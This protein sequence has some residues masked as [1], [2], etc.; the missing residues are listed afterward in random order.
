MKKITF[1]IAVLISSPSFAKAQELSS[2]LS[3]SISTV[4]LIKV[5]VSLLFVLVAIGSFSIIM[6]RLNN[7]SKAGGSTIKI[8][9]SRNVGLKEKLIIVEVSNQQVL[10]G[11]TAHSIN[12]LLTLDK[13]VEVT[14][15]EAKTFLEILKKEKKN[16]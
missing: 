2:Q 16:K 13:R 11:A 7:Y 8:V 3:G 9:S 12:H 1:F 6:K 14:K 5:V 4:E 10:V 15:N